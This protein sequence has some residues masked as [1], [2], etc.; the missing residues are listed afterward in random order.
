MFISHYE[1]L[2]PSTFAPEIAWGTQA[3]LRP[4]CD[5]L[6]QAHYMTQWSP[7][8]PGTHPEISQSNDKEPQSL[9]IAPTKHRKIDLEPHLGARGYRGCYFSPFCVHCGCR[10]GA[11]GRPEGARRTQLE[12]Q[13]LP[14]TPT[15][16]R[17]QTGFLR[18][19]PWVM[20]YSRHPHNHHQAQTQRKYT[21]EGRRHKP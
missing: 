7:K 8:A 9:P 17:K 2:G 19:V 15:D 12:S 1:A 21:Q 4:L 5:A 18:L 14:G 13:S 20:R 11:I 16:H 10:S 3:A 6:R